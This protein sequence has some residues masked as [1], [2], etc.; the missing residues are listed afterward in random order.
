MGTS[1]THTRSIPGYPMPVHSPM[2]VTNSWNHGNAGIV[3][4]ERKV[5]TAPVAFMQVAKPASLR[6]ASCGGPG[7]TVQPHP[8]PRRSR[9]PLEIGS[10]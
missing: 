4:A 7:A 2:D 3:L 5:E 10:S 8:S 9:L 1:F 6:A